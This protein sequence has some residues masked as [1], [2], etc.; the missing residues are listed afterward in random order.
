MF[1]PKSRNANHETHEKARKERD[2]RM[3]EPSLADIVVSDQPDDPDDM[4]HGDLIRTEANHPP[5]S[6][7]GFEV[8]SGVIFSGIRPL[9]PQPLANPVPPPLM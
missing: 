8:F 1:H 3:I 7:A 5:T 4:L 2:L 6:Q 9:T